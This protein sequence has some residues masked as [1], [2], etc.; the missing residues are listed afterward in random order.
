MNLPLLKLRNVSVS[1]SLFALLSACSSDSDDAVH[2]PVISPA[3]YTVSIQASE[4]V[5]VEVDS[6]FVI[7]GDK[8][9]ISFTLEPTH[10]LDSIDGCGVALEGDEYVTAPVTEDCTVHITAQERLIAGRWVIPAA[11]EYFDFGCD[12]PVITHL[13]PVNLNDNDYQDLIVHLSC[14]QRFFG[15]PDSNP[16]PDALVTFYN[17]GNGHFEVANTYV[18]N[19]GVAKL[20]G[21]SRKF[22]RG[23]FTGNGRDDFIFAT[24]WEDGRRTDAS[25][26]DAMP[27]FLIADDDGAYQVLNIGKPVWHHAVRFVPNPMDGLD[28]IF[29]G[30][31]GVN[32]QA[33]RMV[34][35]AIIDVTDEYPDEAT[36]WASGFQVLP[37]HDDEPFITRVVGAW[38]SH[39]SDG[40][41][42]M[43]RNEAGWHVESRF[44]R[45]V[46]FWVDMETWS[47]DKAWTT[48]VEINGELYLGPAFEET[49]Y[50]SNLFGDEVPHLVALSSAMTD[51][52]GK[53]LEEGGQYVQGPPRNILSFFAFDDDNQ[54]VEVDSP[55]ID[56][57]INVNF[58]FFDCV[59]LNDNGLTDIVAYAYTRPWTDEAAADGKPF[60]YLN[61]GSG[62][63]I[64]RNVDDVPAYSNASEF[65]PELQNAMIDMNNNGILD[66]LIVGMQAGYDNGNIEI[67]LF[68]RPLKL[69]Q[70]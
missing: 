15:E 5:Y 22:D 63:L 8:A 24:N 62:H 57:E 33:F 38:S 49:C 16:T 70:E 58:N 23:D 29:S 14:D 68:G 50:A 4:G 35:D 27:A 20:G 46:L 52:D 61:D 3:S 37:V 11:P 41:Q 21:T 39:E 6:I 45:E 60:I 36:H 26:V 69:P 40:F 17:H 53:A 2:P 13:I 44:E 1:A 19:G 65:G 64:R 66:L 34:D 12:N 10:Q 18:F 56:Q 55:I 67:T 43:V 9:S 51:N 32:V 25:P 30:F 48:V 59:D 42:V 47:H 28:A 7:E 31:T 54:L